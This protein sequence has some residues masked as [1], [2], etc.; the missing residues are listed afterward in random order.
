MG[1]EEYQIVNRFERREPMRALGQNRRAP[2]GD[3]EKKGPSW[4]KMRQ[5][6]LT[7]I[8]EKVG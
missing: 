6:L 8:G 5:S 1:A 4:R 7:H 3:T 2:A